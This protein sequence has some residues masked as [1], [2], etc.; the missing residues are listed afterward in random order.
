MAFK[1]GSS[2]NPTGR[3]K[4][5]ANPQ[6]RL[7]TAL[8]ARLEDIIK[9]LTDKALDGDMAAINLIVSRCVSPAKAEST[10]ISVPGAGKTLAE[11]AEAITAAALAGNLSPDAASEFMSILGNLA[12]VMEVADLEARIIALEAGAK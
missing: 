2:G 10:A 1:K 3:P 9:V 12:K 5:I 6:A 4:G 8:G 7:R 11:R